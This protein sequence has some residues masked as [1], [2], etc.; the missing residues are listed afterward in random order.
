MNVGAQGLNQIEP[1]QEKVCDKFTKK[2]VNQ[3]RNIIPQPRNNNNGPIHRKFSVS[4]NSENYLHDRKQSDTSEIGYRRKQ[5]DTSESGY[6][7]R[8]GSITITSDSDKY[9][10]PQKKQVGHEDYE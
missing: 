4:D 8:R 7:R 1:I 9:S 6:Y 10:L 5:S 2:P 3:R